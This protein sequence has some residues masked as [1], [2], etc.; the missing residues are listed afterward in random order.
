METKRVSMLTVRLNNKD[1]IAIQQS[2]IRAFLAEQSNKFSKL[3]NRLK[4]IE[5]R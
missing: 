5:K 2:N 1:N 3:I 4:T